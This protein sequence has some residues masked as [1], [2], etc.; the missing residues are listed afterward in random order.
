MDEDLKEQIKKALSEEV[1][2][3]GRKPMEYRSIEVE[4]GIIE[5]AEGSAKVKIGETEVLCG[6]K[7]EIGTPYPDTPAEG[8]IAVNVEL[9]PLSNP[10]FESGPPGEQAVEVARVVDRGIREAKAVDLKKLCI[11]ENEKVWMVNIDLCTINDS[12][13]LIDASGI[14]ALAALMNARFPKYDGEKI[15]Y[16]KKTDERLPMARLPLP[17]TVLKLGNKFFVDPSSEE[18][19][20]SEVRL[21]ASI[22]EKGTICALQK[23]GEH[24]LTMEDISSMLDIAI[25]K[26]DEIRKAIKGKI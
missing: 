18:E 4:T 15:D 14:A 17:C 12:G 16:H 8:T 10:D 1:R 26:A 5:T 13:N 11:K 23:G 2:L 19:K 6:V 22:T 20:V 24:P 9:L 21:T 3:D 7:M 25:S